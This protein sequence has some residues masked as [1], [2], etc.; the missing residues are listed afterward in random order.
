MNGLENSLRI[1]SIG[2]WSLAAKVQLLLESRYLDFE[3]FVQ[4]GTEDNQERQAFKE[5]D[6]RVFSLLLNSEIEFQ[7]G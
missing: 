3:E 1:F 7:M 2:P 6:V 4:I 5:G